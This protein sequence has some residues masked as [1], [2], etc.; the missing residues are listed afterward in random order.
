MSPGVYR[1]IRHC[2]PRYYRVYID[3]AEA[4][5]LFVVNSRSSPR[6]VTMTRMLIFTFRQSHVIFSGSAIGP[7]YCVTSHVMIF[8]TDRIPAVRRK[9]AALGRFLI[10]YR[11][12]LHPALR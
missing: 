9:R 2:F 8:K 3:F 4:R 1:Y 7:L 5:N 6:H 12:L 10:H 11:A